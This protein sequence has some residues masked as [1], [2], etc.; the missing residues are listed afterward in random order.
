[1]LTVASLAVAIGRDWQSWGCK[2]RIAP[3]TSGRQIGNTWMK[4]EKY[5]G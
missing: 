4:H 5:G 2:V 1:M 3:D